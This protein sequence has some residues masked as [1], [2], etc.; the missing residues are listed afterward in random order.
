MSVTTLPGGGAGSGGS[1]SG[2][3]S[4]LVKGVAG[5]DTTLNS[6]RQVDFV[7]QAGGFRSTLT[8]VAQEVGALTAD[9]TYHITPSVDCWVLV[10]ATGLTAVVG[11]GA[12]AGSTHCKAG[13]TY[14]YVAKAGS[15]YVG[16]IKDTDSSDGYIAVSRVES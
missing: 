13:A 2:G 9:K 14:E 3:S 4:V 16:F 10:G 11:D 8:N 1:G 7:P 15:L 5:D 12:G 6:F